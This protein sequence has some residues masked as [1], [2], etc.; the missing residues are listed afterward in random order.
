[1]HFMRPIIS[2]IAVG[3]VL[4][5]LGHRT[6]ADD[7]KD[8]SGVIDK[9]I[10]SLG[11]EE[12]VDPSKAISWKAKGKL[13]IGGNENE[14]TSK[15]TVQGLDHFRQEFEGEFS[16]SQVKGVTVVAGDKGWRKFGDNARN[17]ENEALATQKR[18]VYLQVI[19]MQP[20]LL[21]GNQGF[22]VESMPD[23]KVGDKSAAV[24]K[25]TGP[26][27]KDFQIFFDKQTGLPLKV[28]AKVSGRN[29]EEFTQETTFSNYKDFDGVKRATKVES[30]RNGENF[31][32]QELTDFKV[33]DKADPKAFEEP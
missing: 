8:A 18:V 31:I 4:L 27:G 7:A 10:K 9:A 29:N 11:G 26:D 14:F 3:A 16:G 19:P 25:A 33:L 12:K 17:L 1:M 5:A 2:T 24:V 32:A 23:E 30:K 13:S 22:K 20:S 28:V 21:K 6:F 15:S